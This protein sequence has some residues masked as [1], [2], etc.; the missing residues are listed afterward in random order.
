MCLKFLHIDLIY[1]TNT[2]CLVMP[3]S[4]HATGDVS[5]CRPTCKPAK[6]VCEK[7][8][9]NT[10]G[11]LQFYSGLLK[12]SLPGLLGFR[13]QTCQARDHLHPPSIL[14]HTINDVSAATI[15]HCPLP[16]PLPHR[17]RREKQQPGCRP[18]LVP[19]LPSPAA[20]ARIDISGRSGAL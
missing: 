18:L 3:S 17:R 6:S 4:R 13:R 14:L 1:T 2:P 20:V 9:V 11:R 19:F 16:R 7:G 8:L 12:A 5:G 15:H 10:C